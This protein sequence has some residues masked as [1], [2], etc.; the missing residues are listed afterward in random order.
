MKITT[1]RE[2]L[3]SVLDR[4]LLAIDRK[5]AAVNV[6]MGGLLLNVSDGTL[7]VT[8]TSQR[9]TVQVHCSVPGSDDG[10]ILVNEPAT[11]AKL[12]KQWPDENIVLEADSRK[13][14]I[15]TGARSYTMPL[16]DP[17]DYPKIVFAERSDAISIDGD[18]FFDAANQVSVAVG[19]D[20]S[21]PMLTGIHLETVADGTTMVATDSYRLA[22]THIDADISSG[23]G[24]NIA[25]L[26]P[27][28]TGTFRSVEKAL[29]TDNFSLIIG[30][31]DLTFY[32]DGGRASVR[33][34]DGTFPAW[35]NLMPGDPQ[36]TLTVDV[37]EFKAALE[38]VSLFSLDHVPVK[39]NV[40]NGIIELAIS[41]LEAGEGAET[42]GGVV[43]GNGEISVGLNIKYLRDGILK[44]GT[45]KVE[46]RFIDA[47]KPALVVP[48]VNEDNSGNDYRYLLMPVRL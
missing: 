29:G 44:C 36:L 1:T 18:E 11:L 30:E 27:A 5:T 34:I 6:V 42:V 39:L 46:L 22:V 40:S 3:A 15:G 19:T 20:D 21:R 10:D 48:V 9:F 32:S 43:E 7:I 23:T 12:V 16:G 4:A 41:R 47:L 33:L 2:K 17:S 38:R 14:T 8:G 28:G 31:R 45:E 13:L 25:A 26:V 24:E 35:R 37:A